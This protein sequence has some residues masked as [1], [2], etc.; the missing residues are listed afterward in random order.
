M[1]FHDQRVLKRHTAGRFKNMRLRLEI[2]PEIQRRPR[3]FETIWRLDIV[4]LLDIAVLH[5][6]F[7]NMK[8]FMLRPLIVKGICWLVLE[9]EIGSEQAYWCFGIRAGQV[10]RL[11]PFA[12]ES[13][14]RASFVSFA[15]FRT[16]CWPV[17]SMFIVHPGLTCCLSC[18]SD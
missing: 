12:L 4:V 8:R 1:L 7:F 11:T 17:C 3:L 2:F 6:S 14:L 15:T 10:L 9:I 18:G 5:Q 13:T 16:C